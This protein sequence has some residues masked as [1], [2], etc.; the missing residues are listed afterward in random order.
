MENNFDFKKYLKENK[1]LKKE[2]TLDEEIQNLNESEQ[3]LILQ[4][5]AQEFASKY[6]KIKIN[7]NHE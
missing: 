4:Q 2:V 1:L 5:K 7:I 3:T 6:G